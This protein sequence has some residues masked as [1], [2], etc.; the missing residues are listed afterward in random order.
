MTDKKQEIYKCGKEL[1]S[2]RGFKD[3]NVADI[4]KAAGV[5]AGTF[6]LYYTSKD[7]LFMEIYIEENEKLKKSIMDA[8]DINGDPLSVI[9]KMI[10]MN[11]A[12]MSA[13][14]VL[15]EW[16]NKD[17]FGR[18]EK[19]FREEK[20]ID[21]VDFMYDTFLKVVRK[22]QYEGKMRRD[23]DSDIIMAILAALINIDTHKEEIGLRYFPQ[24]MNYFAEFVIK[25]LTEHIE[26]E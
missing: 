20:G 24:V 15:K 3:T 22:W 16:Y 9:S 12:G 14:P 17:V 5:A 4:T 8:V 2:S 7:S 18:I 21:S 1:F 10:Y 19:K 13:N 26:K 25:G 6:Y 23:I 11:Y